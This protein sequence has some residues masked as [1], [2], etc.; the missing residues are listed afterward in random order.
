MQRAIVRLNVDVFLP[1]SSCLVDLSVE[2]LLYNTTTL[3]VHMPNA[4][5]TEMTTHLWCLYHIMLP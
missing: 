2:T 3:S 4:K 5:S 1:A